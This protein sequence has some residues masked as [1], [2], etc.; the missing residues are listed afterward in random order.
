MDTALA[1]ASDAPDGLRAIP[2]TGFRSRP[3]WQQVA[4]GTA[5]LA[6]GFF[7]Y[8]LPKTGLSAYWINLAC[9]VLIYSIGTLGFNVAVGWSGQLALAHAG[10]YGL[11]AYTTAVLWKDHGWPF[12]LAMAAAG[13]LAVVVGVLVSWPAM[14]LRGFYLAIATLALGQLFVQLFVQFDSITGGGSGKQVPRFRVPGTGRTE[15]LYYMCLGTAVVCFFIVWRLVGTRLG[16]TLKSVRD[17]EIAAQ[18]VGVQPVKYRLI[19]FGVA[20]GLAAIAGGLQSQYSTFVFPLQ[21]GTALL[22]QF[23]TMMIL[24]GV[25]SMTG[26]V[27]G[28]AFAV[29]VLEFFRKLKPEWESWQPMAF[30]GV[31]MLCV[32]ALPGGLVSLPARLRGLRRRPAA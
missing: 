11:G 21:F 10:F 4:I 29:F 25:G 18:S 15:G 32:A 6:G 12:F 20:S 24:G 28:A 19:A 5:V 31:L 23:L 16:R 30:G 27:I 2:R 8:E 7:L 1:T 26:S 14:P 17:I 9:L 22:V 3:M 13:A